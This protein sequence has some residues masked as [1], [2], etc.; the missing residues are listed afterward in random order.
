MRCPRDKEEVDEESSGQEEEEEHEEEEEDGAPR[1]STDS[2]PS[3]RELRGS[4]EEELER[5]RRVLESTAHLSTGRARGQ[6]GE[7]P[8]VS[9]NRDEQQQRQQL[10]KRLGAEGT[11]NCSRSLSVC[12]VSELCS[13]S[14]TTAPDLLPACDRASQGMP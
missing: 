8:W 10:K 11:C 7:P 13:S 1:A 4:I 14:V 3:L 12:S 6:G 5:A 2:L 9:G